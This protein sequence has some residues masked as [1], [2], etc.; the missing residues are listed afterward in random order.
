MLW[1]FRFHSIWCCLFLILV[2]D[3]RDGEVGSECLCLSRFPGIS[4]AINLQ[5]SPFRPL[6]LP[7]CPLSSTLHL[8]VLPLWCLSFHSSILPTSSFLTTKATALPVFSLQ[9]PASL[10]RWTAGPFF[11]I[12]DLEP[13]SMHFH[14]FFWNIKKIHP[15]ASNS[16]T[17]LMDH[18]SLWDFFF[19]LWPIEMPC[20]TLEHWY[21]WTM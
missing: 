20:L 5:V 1:A 4:Q 19:Q 7:C 13:Q 18:H 11:V 15:H 2:V 6:I 14:S 21:T 17:M 3:L 10:E 9:S 16:H 8:L 12:T